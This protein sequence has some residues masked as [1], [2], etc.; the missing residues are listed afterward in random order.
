[1]V[2]LDKLHDRELTH[3]P[4]VVREQPPAAPADPEPRKPRRFKVVDVMTRRVLAEDVDLRTTVDVLAG[5]RSV[6]DVNLYVWDT[7]SEAWQQLS[8]GDRRRVWALRD[9]ASG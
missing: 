9:R 7:K 2:P 5:L 3:S 1:M 6:V 4:I 8:Q